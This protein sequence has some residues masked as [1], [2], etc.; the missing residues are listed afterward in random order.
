MPAVDRE[1]GIGCE[2]AAM[3]SASASGSLTVTVFMVVA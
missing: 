2:Q 3:S 1:F